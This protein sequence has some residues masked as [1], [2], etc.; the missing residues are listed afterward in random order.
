MIGIKTKASKDTYIGILGDEIEVAPEDKMTKKELREYRHK[1]HLEICGTGISDEWYFFIKWLAIVAMFID[2]LGKVLYSFD[3]IDSTVYAATYIIGRIAFPL[4]A[5]LLVESYFFTKNKKK[6]CI[7]L[8]VLAILSELPYD[9]A[10]VIGTS[11]AESYNYQILASQNVIFTLGLSFFMLMITEK[12]KNNYKFFSIITKGEK[13]QKFC[14]WMIAFLVAFTIGLITIFFVTD[15]LVFGMLL[16]YGFYRAK[17]AKHTK[18][19]QAVVLLL[20]T[21]LTQQFWLHCAILFALIPMY[22]AEC[23]SVKL[24]LP[25]NIGKLVTSRASRTIGRFFYPA[26]LVLLTILKFILLS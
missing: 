6:H 16:V 18:I 11:K 21:I 4:F 1:K 13:R 22:M 12:I 9:L 3:R 7:Q 17:K 19:W 15:Y 24:E 8:F 25:K 26:H 5:F 2:H 23:E 14:A 20:F 10:L